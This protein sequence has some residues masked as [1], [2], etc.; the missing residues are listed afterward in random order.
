MDVQ[1]LKR[2]IDLLELIGRDTRLKQV[3]RT[4]GGE[5]AGPCPFCAA[6]IACAFSLSAACG[7]AGN[8]A[9]STGRMPSHM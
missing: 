2:N 1:S 8:A 6:R 5:W 4:A 7:G 9:A 3:A